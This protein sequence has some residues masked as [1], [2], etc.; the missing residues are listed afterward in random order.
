MANDRMDTKLY[1]WILI[2]S[3]LAER[4]KIRWGNDTKEDLRIMKVNN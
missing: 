3:R 4:P 2:S 1:Q